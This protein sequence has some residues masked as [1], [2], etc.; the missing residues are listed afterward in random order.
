MPCS[1]DRRITAG[2]ATLADAY[3]GVPSRANFLKQ[4]HLFERSADEGGATKTT[5]LSEVSQVSTSEVARGEEVFGTSEL[6]P[7]AKV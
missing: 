3:A 4:A 7:H 1:E 5:E 6:R 2:G